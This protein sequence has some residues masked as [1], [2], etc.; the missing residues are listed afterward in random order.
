MKLN[1]FFKLI[2]AIV[3]CELAGLIGSIFTSPAIPTWYAGLI[4]PAL[5]PPAWVF[6]PAWTTLYALMGIAAFLVWKKTAENKKVNPALGWFAAQLALNVLWSAIFFG[7]KSPGAALVE[8]VLL[9]LAIVAAIFA[10]AKISK[11][12]AWL[13]LPYLLWVSYAGLLNYAVW[14]LNK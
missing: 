9:W 3:V 5:N 10:F 1:N 12:A 13:L 8:I 11:T 7:L 4:K 14:Q 6:A 2:T